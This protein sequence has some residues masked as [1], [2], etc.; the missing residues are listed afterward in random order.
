[1]IDRADI[2][3]TSGDYVRQAR[4]LR[5]LYR[6][7]PH[8]LH[9]SL[10]RLSRHHDRAAGAVPQRS[11]VRRVVVEENVAS[12]IDRSKRLDNRLGDEAAEFAAR[13]RDA[14]EAG[15]L[16]YSRRKRLLAEAERRGIGRFDA[17]L[18]IAAVQHRAQRTL[19]EPSRPSRIRTDW[20]A[21][22]LLQC[23]ILAA[24]WWMVC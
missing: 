8:R 16:R 20:I 4:R 3:T 10:I 5:C 23:C 15:V 7:D 9:H 12:G 13:C 19:V 1:M 14:I 21:A 18:I 2:A 24:L 6:D 17:N 11:R 22:A